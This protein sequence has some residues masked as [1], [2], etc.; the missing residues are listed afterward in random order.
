MFKG[1]NFT[2]NELKNF[3]AKMFKFKKKIMPFNKEIHDYMNK[4]SVN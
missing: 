2:Q 1:L 3:S 4:S